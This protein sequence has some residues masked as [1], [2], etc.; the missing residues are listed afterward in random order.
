MQYYIAMTPENIEGASQLKWPT[1][2]SAYKIGSDGRLYRALNAP[3]AERGFM[4]LNSDE[5]DPPAD[6]YTVSEIITECRNRTFSGVVINFVSFELLDLLSPALSSNKLRLIVHEEFAEKYGDAW[7]LVSSALS[8]GTLKSRLSEAC[9]LI[10]ASRIV[11]DVE[12]VCRDF[13]LPSPSGEGRELSREEF[14]DLNE[15]LSPASYFSPELC[16][17]YFHYSENEQM[18]FVLYDNLYSIRTKLQLAE[19]LNINKALFLYSEAKNI[20]LNL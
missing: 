9:D 13:T 20:L 3:S 11:L 8:G 19:S 18:H 16:C 1:A 14:S 4:I 6:D 2:Y 5:D 7:V 10:G 12:R 15:R 17:Y